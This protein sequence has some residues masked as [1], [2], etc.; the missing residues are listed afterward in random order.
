MRAGWVALVVKNPPGNAGEI[1]ENSVM[2]ESHCM[3]LGNVTLLL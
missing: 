3:Y 2:H 1:R